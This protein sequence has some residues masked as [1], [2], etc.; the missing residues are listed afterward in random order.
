MLRIKELNITKIKKKNILIISNDEEIRNK[1]K[2]KILEQFPIIKINRETEEIIIQHIYKNKKYNLRILE[3]TG[4]E[5]N[6]LRKL[7][8]VEISS[9]INI[10]IFII[11]SLHYNI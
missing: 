3:S 2:K 11:F 7:D 9:K 10:F 1:I 8:I 6:T 5:T 4:Y